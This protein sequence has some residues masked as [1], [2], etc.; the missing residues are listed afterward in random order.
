[1][2]LNA[3][4]VEAKHFCL[5]HGGAM[6]ID[7]NKGSKKKT[8]RIRTKKSTKSSSKHSSSSETSKTVCPNCNSSTS[9]RQR[10]FSHQA[11]TLLLLWNEINPAAIHHPLCDTCYNEMRDLLIERAEEV[12][13][14]LKCEDKYKFAAKII[15]KIKSE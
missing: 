15:D 1:M 7:V 14:D 8:P 2:S 5:L 3:F 11:W 10:T 13:D 9:T 4:K 12:N 6:E